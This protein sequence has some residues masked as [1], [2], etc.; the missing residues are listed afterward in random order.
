[1]A[2]ENIET[3]FQEI[4]PHLD[5]LEVSRAEGQMEWALTFE[6]TETETLTVFVRHEADPDHFVFKTIVGAIPAEARQKF[7]EDMMAFNSAEQE[8][9][10]A[11]FG[12]TGPG[13]DAVLMFDYGVSD[14]TTEG[15]GTLLKQFQSMAMAWRGILKS[16]DDETATEPLPSFENMIR[17]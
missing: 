6:D 9:G 2:T 15:L 17:G 8:T 7:L 1:M 12:V 13:G 5:L 10:G 11:R 14:I 3:L 4:G 16:T